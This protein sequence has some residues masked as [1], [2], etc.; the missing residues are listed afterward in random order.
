MFPNLT[1]GN[2]HRAIKRGGLAV[3][4]CNLQI[5]ESVM[6]FKERRGSKEQHYVYPIDMSFTNVQYFKPRFTRN[7]FTTG[8]VLSHP[9]LNR[10][11]VQVDSIAEL[12]YEAFLIVIPFERR[13]VNFAAGKYQAQRGPINEGERF[14]CIYDQTYGSLRLSGRILEGDLLQK[15]FDRLIEVAQHDETV[16]LNHETLDAIGEIRLSLSEAMEDIFFEDIVKIVPPGRVERVIMPGSKGLYLLGSNEERVVED[17]FFSPLDNALR[18]R[19]KAEGDE[20]SLQ[21]II[22]IDTLAEI[23]GESKLGLYNY[24]T[25]EIEPIP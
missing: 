11:R 12:L 1:T 17:I 20:S 18:Y 3:I 14:L 21:R 6:G 24:E 2:V 16:E 9:V 22:A 5:R 4:E 13:D 23:P 15:T 19:V 25:G 8:V 10:E 7:Y